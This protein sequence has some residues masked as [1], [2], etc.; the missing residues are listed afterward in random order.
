MARNLTIKEIANA[1]NL[2]PFWLGD[3]GG[4]HQY[5][6]PGPLFLTL[7][8]I[9]LN[10]VLKTFEDEWSFRWLPYGRQVMFDRREL[11]VDDLE[12]MVQTYAK[13]GGKALFPDANEFRTYM[14]WPEL[15]ESAWPAPPPQ[16]MPAGED[17]ADPADQDPADQDP[18]EPP[19]T[20]EDD[21]A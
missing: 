8:R 16:L 3:S 2:D 10:P 14:G 4:S 12:T 11:L 9:S 21:A 7:L 19:A 1:F 15:P 18:P 20:E 17:P 6:S 5:K 13:S